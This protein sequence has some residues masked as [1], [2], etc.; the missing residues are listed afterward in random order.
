MIS[1]ENRAIGVNNTFHTNQGADMDCPKCSEYNDTQVR[2]DCWSCGKAFDKDSAKA[3]ENDLEVVEGS[4]WVT[5]EFIGDITFNNPLS[6]KDLITVVCVK[7][8][9][10]EFKSYLDYIN[11]K[12]DTITITKSE[13]IIKYR[14][15]PSWS[16]GTKIVFFLMI[17]IAIPMLIYIISPSMRTPKTVSEPYVE[18]KTSYSEAECSLEAIEIASRVKT[19]I[20]AGQADYFYNID[21]TD[22]KRNGC[23]K[24]KIMTAVRAMQ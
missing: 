3:K 12:G 9:K 23:S 20:R 24:S 4:K 15:K 14:P 13:F 16:I 8:G 6:I 5:N 1:T 22:Y 2:T 10:V 21:L 18:Y 7:D 19:N 17:A 11:K